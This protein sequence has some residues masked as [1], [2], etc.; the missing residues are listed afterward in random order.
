MAA[1]SLKRATVCSKAAAGAHREAAAHFR[2]G[3]LVAFIDKKP[4]LCH[5]AIST[6]WMVHYLN[7]GMTECAGKRAQEADAMAN[8]DRTFAHRHAAAFQ[9]LHERLGRLPAAERGDPGAR[10]TGDRA[11][12]AVPAVRGVD[13]DVDAALSCADPEPVR[14]CEPVGDRGGHLTAVGELAR[15][16]VRTLAAVETVRRWAVGDAGDSIDPLPP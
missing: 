1:C 5:M 16:Q 11:E 7:A 4:F 12:T 9:A 2:L 13:V 3:N 10:L 14:L 6:N 15:D 8:F